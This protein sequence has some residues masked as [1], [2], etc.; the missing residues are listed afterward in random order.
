MAFLQ[1]DVPGK[2]KNEDLSHSP[3]PGY[4][5]APEAM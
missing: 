4:K 3:R 1:R 5:A 2:W